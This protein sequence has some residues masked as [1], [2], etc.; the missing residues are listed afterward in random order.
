MK[1]D[2]REKTASGKREFWGEQIRFW[3]ESG[4]SQNEYCKRHSIRQSQWFYWRRRCR[5]TE[6]GLTLVPLNLPNRQLHKTSVVRVTTPN[7]FT[8]ELDADA[9]LTTL[10]QLI[11][12]VA[13]I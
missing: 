12:E 10:P 6:E 7:G 9:P 5:D 13:A 8:I 1:I 4:L 2:Y 11:R 3:Q